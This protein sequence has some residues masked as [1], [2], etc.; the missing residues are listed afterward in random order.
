GWVP[1]GESRSHHGMTV[2]QCSKRSDNVR[3][4]PSTNVGICAGDIQRS[5]G[6]QIENDTDVPLLDQSRQS[7]AT[8]RKQQLVRP[9]WQLKGAIK[10]EVMF[11]AAA[12]EAPI[13]IPIQYVYPCGRDAGCVGSDATLKRIRCLKVGSLCRP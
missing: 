1:S 3:P 4:S 13:Q 7:S 2:L 8:I 9:Y 11:A 12:L 5:P 6:K 10:P